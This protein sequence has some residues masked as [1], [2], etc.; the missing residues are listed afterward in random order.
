TI[1][2]IKKELPI[3]QSLLCLDLV[4][5]PVLS[6]IK[7]QAPRL[8]MPFRQFLSVSVLRPCFPQIPKFLISRKVPR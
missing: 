2:K 6:Q 3:C 7:P 8:V 4:S 1:Q 5:F